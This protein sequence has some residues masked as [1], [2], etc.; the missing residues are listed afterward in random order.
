MLVAAAGFLLGDSLQGNAANPM[1]CAGGL[2]SRF[3]GSEGRR[4]GG[5]LVMIGP[6]LRLR[7][8]QSDGGGPRSKRKKGER[9]MMNTAGSWNRNGQWAKGSSKIKYMQTGDG[10]S[11]SRA[12]MRRER[13]FSFDR[14]RPILMQ[15]LTCIGDMPLHSI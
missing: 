10:M 15:S 1:M 8:G 11:F 7:G 12:R 13:E 9:V 5:R 14:A 4:L 3:S 6:S 2:M